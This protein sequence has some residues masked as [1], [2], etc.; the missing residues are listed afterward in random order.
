MRKT[1]RLA[2]LLLG[3]AVVV[4]AI[5]R[6]FTCASSPPPLPEISPPAATGS[7]AG[8]GPAPSR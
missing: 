8:T 2:T 4:I 7:A 6:F 3:L 5:W 1:P